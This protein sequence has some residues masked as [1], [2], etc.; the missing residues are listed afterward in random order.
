MFSSISFT[1][2]LSFLVYKSFTSLVE[3]ITKYF[4]PFD[5]FTNWIV[6]LISLLDSSFLVF[7]NGTGFY[8]LNLY[9]AVLFNLLVLT[10]LWCVCECV[11]VI[12]RI[13]YIQN[14]VI[15]KKETIL[16]L[17]FLFGCLLFLFL[18]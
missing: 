18:A 2:A 3:F 6:F 12:F 17:S 10:G 16:L 5:T 1:S 4:I 14:H 9:P 11:C 13:F 15:S 7:R 8:M